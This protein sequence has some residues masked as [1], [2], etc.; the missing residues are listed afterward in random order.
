MQGIA[1]A[2]RRYDAQI[3]FRHLSQ[4]WVQHEATSIHQSLLDLCGNAQSRKH[5]A[6]PR[7]ALVVASAP[8]FFSVSAEVKALTLG[9]SRLACGG[10][11]QYIAVSPSEA[12][13]LSSREMRRDKDAK[14]KVILH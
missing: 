9:L 2:P 7:T 14:Y 10:G 5:G 3:G 1:H 6:L 8:G 13:Y 11:A 4:E 12:R